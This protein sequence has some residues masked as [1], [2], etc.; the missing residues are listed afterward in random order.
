MKSF[1]VIRII[2]YDVKSSSSQI[3][4]RHIQRFQRIT[5]HIFEH[6]I[7]SIIVDL[8]INQMNVLNFFGKMKRQFMKNLVG[9]AA[10][11]QLYSMKVMVILEC[12][13]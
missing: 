2:F 13:L 7:K 8:V 9:D 11:I 5:M 12:F 3:V 10:G 1:E 4:I 6:A